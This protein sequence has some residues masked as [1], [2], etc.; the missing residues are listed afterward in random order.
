[1]IRS[2]D[3][4][5]SW[6]KPQAGDAAVQRRANLSV[7]SAERFRGGAGSPSR[8]L[9]ERTTDP[10]QAGQPHHDTKPNRLLSAFAS[11]DAVPDEL[12]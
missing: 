6:S 8:P 5:A 10:K 7:R 9:P 1:M 3:V 11:S 12:R 4:A 2:A